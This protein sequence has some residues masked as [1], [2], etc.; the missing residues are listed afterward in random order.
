MHIRAVGYWM[1]V[2]I[3]V[4]AA[5]CDSRP[6][7]VP[8]SGQVLIDGEPLKFGAIMFVPDEGR[9]S[10]GMVD[11]SGHFKLT[12]FQAGDGALPGTHRIHIYPNESINNTTMKW[13]APKKYTDISTSGLTQTIDE[14][15]DSLLIE[16]TWKGSTPDKP[17]IERS[18]AAADD[19]AY[20]KSRRN[21]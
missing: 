1:S 19:D 15:T 17:F 8:V 2:A 20:L 16:L 11:A 3:A 10:S 9:Q 6:T 5:G 18:D 12:C 7:C 21:R 14:P 13:H 4:L